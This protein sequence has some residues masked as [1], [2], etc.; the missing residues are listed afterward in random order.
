MLK[1]VLTLVPV[2]KCEPFST[3]MIL[4]VKVNN[5]VQKEDFQNL[6]NLNNTGK[7]KSC[8]RNVLQVQHTIKIS[9][10]TKQI[11]TQRITNI[12]INHTLHLNH[13]HR[14][15]RTTDISLRA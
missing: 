4:P 13:Y 11:S 10:N 2:S 9:G 5:K 3:V 1:V 8:R 7:K 15:Q 14:R 6:K 12:H